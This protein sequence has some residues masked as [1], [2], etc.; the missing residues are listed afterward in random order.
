MSGWCSLICG[1][2]LINY[3]HLIT[4]MIFINNLVQL[5]CSCFTCTCANA[6]LLKHHKRYFIRWII[7]WLIGIKGI[8][9]KQHLFT[10]EKWILRGDKDIKI[11]QGNWYIAP[12]FKWATVVIVVSKTYTNYII[13]WC[14]SNVNDKSA[15]YT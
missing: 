2:T 15:T 9:Y 12:C 3:F 8:Y 7:L 11:S 13:I 4:V 5:Y 10:C 6:N 1:Q 14:S